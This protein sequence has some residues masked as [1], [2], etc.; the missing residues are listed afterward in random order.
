M[1][2]ESFDDLGPISHLVMCFRDSS[3]VGFCVRVRR[4]LFLLFKLNK[5]T[6]H[7]LVKLLAFVLDESSTCLDLFSSESSN[8]VYRR[9]CWLCT[10]DFSWDSSN[11]NL[12][13]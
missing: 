4:R 13:S 6:L 11:L 7:C 3:V 8:V 1:M 2:F 10:V 9:F 5:M 12:E